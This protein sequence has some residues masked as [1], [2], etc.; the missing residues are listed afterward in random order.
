M[1]YEKLNSVETRKPLTARNKCGKEVTL[2]LKYIE[3]PDRLHF[4]LNRL[5]CKGENMSNASDNILNVTENIRYFDC[6]LFV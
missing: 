4:H 2:F 1:N 3:A 5:S 6:S